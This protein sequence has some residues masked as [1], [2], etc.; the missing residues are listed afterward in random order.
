MWVV[1]FPAKTICNMCYSCYHHDPNEGALY[2]NAV[3]RGRVMDGEW[4]RTW[5]SHS[6][7]HPSCENGDLHIIHMDHQR[8]P[9]LAD[10]FET[11]DLGRPWTR[12]GCW[13]W[14]WLWLDASQLLDRDDGLGTQEDWA[15]GPVVH[16]P[17]HVAARCCI[18]SLDPKPTW[19]NVFKNIQN[20][21]APKW[22]C[23]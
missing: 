14:I 22:R 15:V 19:I 2:I 8:R 9:F 13:S 12:Y 5:N 23:W 20:W 6:R 4:L 10:F 17:A 21:G 7:M 16:L 18:T 1:S 3:Q 11:L